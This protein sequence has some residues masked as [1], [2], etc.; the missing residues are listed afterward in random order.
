MYKEKAI[1]A[2]FAVSASTISGWRFISNKEKETKIV[3]FPFV[4]SCWRHG[5]STGEAKQGS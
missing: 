1:F 2:D 3:T 5:E 4:R